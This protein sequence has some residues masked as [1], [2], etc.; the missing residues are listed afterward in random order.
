MTE[1]KKDKVAELMTSWD[2]GDFLADRQMPESTVVIHLN[3][4]ASHAKAQLLRAHAKATGEE[5]A[6]LDKKLEEVEEAL[7]ASRY[8]IHLRAIS[9]DMREDIHERALEKFPEKRNF[10]GQPSE[11]DPTRQRIRFENLLLWQAC[12]RKM[13]TPKGDVFENPTDGDV[14]ALDTGSPSGAKNMI[15]RAIR[16]LHEDAE[17]FTAEVKNPDF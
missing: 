10:L 6:E 12:I 14:E 7:A 13:V 11:D 3:E 16:E 15:D 1:E 4:F 8:E 9:S 2:L 5:V 17:R